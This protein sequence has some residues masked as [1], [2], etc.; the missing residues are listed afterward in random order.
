MEAWKS[1]KRI[2]STNGDFSE[3]PSISFDG[4]QLYFHQKIS[5]LFSIYIVERE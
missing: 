5:G 4:R 3:A 2:N 1:I